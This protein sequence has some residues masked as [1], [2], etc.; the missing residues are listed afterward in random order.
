[1]MRRKSIKMGRFWLTA[2]LVAAFAVT[3]A[4][5][6]KKDREDTT[7]RALQGTVT[8]PADQPVKGAVVQLKDMRTLQVRSFITQE[9]GAYHFSGLKTDVDYEVKADFS[10]MSSGSKTLS[11]FDSRKNPILNL[12]LEKK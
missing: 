8:D 1:M 11:V 7:T 3:A 4:A 12:K 10:G 6:R 9:Q 2:T 5:Q